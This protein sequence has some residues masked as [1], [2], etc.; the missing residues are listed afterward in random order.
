[1]GDWRTDLILNDWR[2]EGEIG[3]GSNAMGEDVFSLPRRFYPMPEGG[4]CPDCGNYMGDGECSSCE[5]LM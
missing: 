2:M 5:V 3:I 4:T 1:M